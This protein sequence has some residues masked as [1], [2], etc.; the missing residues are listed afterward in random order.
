MTLLYILCGLTL[1]GFLMMIRSYIKDDEGSRIGSIIFLI[2]LGFIGWLII[3]T[4]ADVKVEKKSAQVVEIIKGTHVSLV[5]AKDLCQKK[6]CDE[7][8]KFIRKPDE[9]AILNDSSKFEWNVGYNI[10]GREIYH[11]LVFNCK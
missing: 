2:F 11:K 8:I 3:G 4:E 9:L 1:G 6:E 10:Y 7:N 5:I